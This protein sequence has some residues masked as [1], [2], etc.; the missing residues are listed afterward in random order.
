MSAKCVKAI[1]ISVLH[2]GHRSQWQVHHV[3][4]GS[5]RKP[6]RQKIRTREKQLRLFSSNAVDANEC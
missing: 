6:L 5:C 1:N 3:G 2:D 4:R